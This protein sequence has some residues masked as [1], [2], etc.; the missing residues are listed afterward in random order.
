MLRGEYGKFASAAD[1]SLPRR[2]K[3][4]LC[5]E[6][7][8]VDFCGNVDALVVEVGDGGNDMDEDEQD[9]AVINAGFAS[10]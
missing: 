6:D 3:V 1:R 5:R 9:L 4:E 2:S 8:I 10:R 7:A